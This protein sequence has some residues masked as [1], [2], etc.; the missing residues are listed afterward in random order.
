MSLGFKKAHYNLIEKYTICDS[1][2]IDF[3]TE[4][5]NLIYTAC[6]LKIKNLNFATMVLSA[7]F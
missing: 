4:L 7:I 1:L 2:R 5:I 3:L 6:C